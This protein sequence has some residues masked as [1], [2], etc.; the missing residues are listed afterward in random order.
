MSS[1]ML[2]SAAV[3]DRVKVKVESIHW[4]HKK[5]LMP[6]ADDF[7]GRTPVWKEETITEWI[8]TRNNRNI[9]PVTKDIP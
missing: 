1:P 7:Y 8:A 5:G 3:A 2:D 9:D 4:Y 6:P